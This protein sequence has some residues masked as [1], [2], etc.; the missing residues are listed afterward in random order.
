MTHTLSHK[1]VW[2]TPV[3]DRGPTGEPTRCS[4]CG[5]EPSRI[6]CVNCGQEE[7]ESVIS[8]GT[9][10]RGLHSTSVRRDAR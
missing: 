6:V 1:P 4:I 10:S 3:D 2:V 9:L 7:D 8:H 5:V